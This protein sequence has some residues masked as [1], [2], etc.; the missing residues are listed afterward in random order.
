M[1]ILLTGGLGFVGSHL[2]SNINLR[3]IPKLQ[4]KIDETFE[5]AKKIENILQ[6]I[7]K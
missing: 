3:Q 6:K 1:N 4:F 2:S 5:Y 7:K